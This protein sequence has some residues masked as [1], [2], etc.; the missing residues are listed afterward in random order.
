MRT[1]FEEPV[2]A[3]A[4]VP[5]EETKKCPFCAERIL[6]EAIKCRHC[7]EFLCGKPS[8]SAPKSGGKWYQSNATIVIALLTLG[9]LAL[10]MVWTNRRYSLVVKATITVSMLALTIGL[11]Y[12]MMAMYQYVINQIQ[13]LGI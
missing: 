10:P 11:C 7:G 13:S 5:P 3:V 4:V 12:G 9:P 6:A 2:E 1:S 8:P